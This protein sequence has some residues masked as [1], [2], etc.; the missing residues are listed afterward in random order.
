[1]SDV[2]MSTES[3]QSLTEEIVGPFVGKLT[4]A[5]LTNLERRIAV[6]VLHA[7]SDAAKAA[8]GRLQEMTA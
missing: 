3:V 1:M 4:D 6:A 2:V 5:D 7:Q 8:L